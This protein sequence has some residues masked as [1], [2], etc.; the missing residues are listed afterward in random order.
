MGFQEREISGKNLLSSLEK[1]RYNKGKEVISEN[2]NEEERLVERDFLQLHG[3]RAT[4]AGMKREFDEEIEREKRE[5]NAKLETLNLSLA[6]PDI[7]LS[8]TSLP[9]A[10]PPA[11]PKPAR[12]THSL[13]PS[14]NNTVNTRTAS[15]DDFTV[16]SI[17]Y[18]YSLPFSHNP[19][20]SLTRNSTENYE[21]SVGSNRRDTDQI[22]YCGEGT[23]GSVHSRFRPVSRGG[24]AL[25]S[26]GGG[27]GTSG[28][29][30]SVMQGNRQINKDPCNS[31]Y[32][33]T[34]SDNQS[35]F[36]SELQAKQR[37]DTA[38]VDSRGRASVKNSDGNRA[39]K[40]MRLDRILLEIVCDSIPDMAQIMQDLP[41][42]TIESAKEH[43]RN[44]IGS[45]DKREIL[46]NLQNRLE[47]RSDLTFDSLSKSHRE[48]LEILVAI[49]TGLVNYISAKNSLPMTELA[50]IFL[51]MRCRNVNCKGLLPVDDCD[52]KIC[53]TKKGFCSACMCPVCLNF[54]CASETCSWVG[55]D[56]CS[57]WC[58]AS[59][60]IKSNLIKPGPSL[61]GPGRKTEMQFHCLG[62]D[63]AS[64][65][66]GFI[67]DVFLCCAKKWG[68]E[69]LKKE[70]D[71]VRKI[72]RRSEEF[73]GKELQS[74]AEEILL[75]LENKIISPSEACSSIL[76]FFK[77]GVSEISGSGGSSKDLTVA[78][79]CQ[80]GDV[81]SVSPTS[82]PS[83]S[84][85][86]NMSSSSGRQDL[87]P[88]DVNEKNRKGAL[89]IDR[90][91]ED[92]L[93][94]VLRMDGFD[95]LESIVRVKEAE[96]RMFQSHADEARR[97]AKEYQRMVRLNSEKLEEEYASK[98]SKLC[99]QE[100]EERRRKKLE[101][102]KILESSHCD[103]YKMKLRMKVEIAGLLERMEATKKQW[104]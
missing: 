75:K 35:F 42:D 56:V 76:Q 33:A 48:Q 100:T 88:H 6:L 98:L 39:T 11:L 1:D 14:N 60:G 18:S 47:R 49:K 90:T 26:H 81:V 99:L 50:E 82:P 8:L 64:E 41:D 55:C 96:A 58:H 73:K 61:K 40:L 27:G 77:Y 89:M 24:V 84:T 87:L 34:S 59:C 36:P 79:M 94:S 83:K 7:S 10:E 9:N 62:C 38:S 44:L 91:I 85:T 29:G 101:E 17:S 78:Q 22:W 86:Y 37:I 43:L 5:K 32:T 66:F 15:S 21:Y 23:N 102:I 51:L 70:L 65:M 4:A 95:S 53:S 68:I 45:S 103:Y 72:F 25:S 30:H 20:C 12:S 93:Q 52:C 3:V 2:P 57:H 80:K 92:E 67:K 71:C 63:H 19:S 46:T 74:K 54:D 31:L 104:V 16:A 13:A 97:E 28:F 69:A